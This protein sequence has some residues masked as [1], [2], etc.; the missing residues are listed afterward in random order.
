MAYASSDVDEVS[1]EYSSSGSTEYQDG[2]PVTDEHGRTL[3]A[4]DD[5]H[6]WWTWVDRDPGPV[7][8]SHILRLC[9]DSETPTDPEGHPMIAFWM[10]RELVEST[11][12]AL[13]A[14]AV[15][16][17]HL[18]VVTPGK[19]AGREAD[20]FRALSAAVRKALG[21]E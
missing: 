1:G 17:D 9:Q 4:C 21:D 6:E 20:R 15:A 3:V 11:A 19:D 8:P 7:E 14:A 2:I 16:I 12:R 13:D 5:G 10:S 18:G